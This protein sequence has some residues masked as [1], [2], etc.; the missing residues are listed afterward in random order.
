MYKGELISIGVAISWTLT[1]LCFEYS[2]K[3]IG[4]L[5][6]NIIRLECLSVCWGVL[7]WSLPA[8]SFR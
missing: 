2:G 1:A 4:A 6:L 5:S 8:L 7:C 3:R